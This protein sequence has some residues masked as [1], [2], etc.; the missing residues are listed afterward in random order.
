MGQNFWD[1]EVFHILLHLYTFGD[2]RSLSY[3]NLYKGTL[4]KHPFIC[5]TN[6][7]SRIWKWVTMQG[8]DC[9]FPNMD[10]QLNGAFWPS[11]RMRRI[12]QKNVMNGY[13]GKDFWLLSFLLNICIWILQFFTQIHIQATIYS[14]MDTT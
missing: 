2:M 14:D 12:W 9:L 7:P 5:P 1:F 11:R 13:L 4:T 10:P 6:Y 3:R 8:S